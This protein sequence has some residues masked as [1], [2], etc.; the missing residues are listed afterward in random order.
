MGC[1]DCN[2]ACFLFRGLRRHMQTADFSMR[3]VITPATGDYA[4][5]GPGAHKQNTSSTPCR[6]DRR[7]PPLIALTL[8]RPAQDPPGFASSIAQWPS[9]TVCWQTVTATLLRPAHLCDG[10]CERGFAVIN[11]AN[12][13][14]IEVRLCACVDVI[15]R[16]CLH[17]P[18]AEGR[19]AAGLQQPPERR[20]QKVS[21]CRLVNEVQLLCCKSTRSALKC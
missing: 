5:G 1:G 19:Q 20:R 12:G 3:D 9:H 10:C 17:E 16:R 18:R 11:V 2:S 8:P 6:S 7:P 15:V 21:K 4:I 13:A 14:H